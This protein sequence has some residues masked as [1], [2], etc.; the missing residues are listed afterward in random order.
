MRLVQA[1]QAIDLNLFAMGR[2][3]GLVLHVDALSVLFALMGTGLG[4]FVLLYS[5]GYMAHDKSATRFYAT[6]LVFIGGFV[7]LVYSANLFIFYLCWELVGLCSFSLVGFWYTN[8]EAVHGARKVLLMTHIAGYGLLAA[9]L[10]IYHRTGSALWTDPAVAH[11]FTGGVFVLMLVALVAK[12]RAGAA[13]HVDSRSHGRAHAGERAA[14]RGLLREGRRLSGC[15]H[16]QLW[17]VAGGVG[18]DPDVDRHR[19]HGRRRDVRHGADRSEAHAGLLHREPDRLH[20]DG[21]RHRHAAGDY[22]RPA[23]LPQSRILQGRAVSD[24]RLG[25][26]RRRHARHEQARRPGAEDAAAPRCPG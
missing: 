24:R 11:A 19:H 25:A 13:A 23:A 1:G 26:A 7:G 12:S 15:A 22:R 14:A 20:D 21:H 10:V 5:I 16:A 17:R 4:G 18:R 2:T 9:I 8:R 6:M 3:A